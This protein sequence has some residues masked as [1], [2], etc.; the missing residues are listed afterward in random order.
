MTERLRK[1]F[2]CGHPVA[3][4]RSPL[5]HGHW[6]REY[7]IDG[8][9]ERVDV[10]PAD[11]QAFART[12]RENGYCGGNVTLPH[13]E[14]AAAL[15][16]RLEPASET[17]GAVNTLWLEGDALVGDNSDAYGFAASLD[18]TI[19]GWERGGAA[20]VLGAGGAARAI[21]HALKERDFRDIRVVNRTPGRG[22]ELAQRFGEGI[23]AH[24]WGASVELLGDTAL[25]VNT[26]QLGMH[27][28]KP[29]EL[30]L[31]RL[32]DTAIV[33]DIVY[34]PLVTELMV[35]AQRRGLRTVGGI[36]MLL[37]QAVP[38]FERWFGV[39]PQVTD[40]LRTLAETD[41]EKAA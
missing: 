12:L 36:G 34:V 18:E 41:V 8:S 24:P 19:A 25:L 39:R 1:A 4:S 5:I 11:F 6:L 33:A 14:A 3:H 27:G 16:D 26:T 20:T 2:V 40:A 9:Y 10:A 13:K 15:A 31:D 28:Q 38:G 30:A 23:S 29:L 21:I 32:P 7:G 37:H 22:L 17:I 35:R